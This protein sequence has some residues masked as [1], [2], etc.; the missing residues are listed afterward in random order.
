MNASHLPTHQSNK[1]PSNILICGNGE[2]G[3]HGQEV[4]DPRCRLHVHWHQF[5]EPAY[6]VHATVGLVMFLM[7]LFSILGNGFVILVYSK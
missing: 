1:T 2:T 7:S 3:P 4:D 5:E 6:G